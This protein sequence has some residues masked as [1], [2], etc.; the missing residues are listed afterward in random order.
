MSTHYVYG[1]LDSRKSEEAEQ[2]N[3]TLLGPETLGIEVTNQVHVQSCGLGNID[4]QHTEGLAVTATLRVLQMTGAQLPPAG[5]ILVTSKMDLD[6]ATAMALVTIGADPDYRFSTKAMARC[7]QVHSM[8]L[9]L[10]GDYPGHRPLPSRDEP[11]PEKGETWNLRE[12][13]PMT[14]FVADWKVSPEDRVMGVI[15]W[16]ETGEYPLG[17]KERVEKERQELIGALESNSIRIEPVQRVSSHAICP[18]DTIKVVFVESS[19]RAATTVGYSVAPVVV[20]L[21]PRHTQ[22][23]KTY[24]KFTICQYR[25][26]YVD[27][28]K[29]FAELSQ[30]EAGWA[31]SPAIGGSPIGQDST[32]SP[33]QVIEVVERHLID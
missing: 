5:S 12:L 15:H 9:F 7:W 19:H 20:A 25:A 8:D 18:A 6:S 33:S 2:H 32:L 28:G 26:G 29:V 3:A 27:L 30:L 24:R 21:N 4:P 14:A 17:Y 22:D 1:I 23:G 16:L 31:G 10:A 13:A 11:W